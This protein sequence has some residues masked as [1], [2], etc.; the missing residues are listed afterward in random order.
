MNTQIT[1]L[2]E[3]LDINFNMAVELAF[4]GIT[5]EPFSIESLA[6]Q[7]NSIALYMAVIQTFNPDSKITIERLVKEATNK[8]I[9]A[10]KEAVAKAMFAWLDI[11]AVAAQE[12]RPTEQPAEPEKNA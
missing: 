2:G 1:I 10:L 6:Y 5:D 7:K 4:E 3:T 12:E 11:P 9:V 8:E